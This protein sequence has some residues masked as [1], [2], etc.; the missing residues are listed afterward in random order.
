MAFTESD[1]WDLIHAERTR[2]SQM[3][4]NLSLEHWQTQ[5]LCTKWTIEEVVAHLTAGAHTG[6][7]EWMRSMALAGFNPAIHNVRRLTEHLGRTPQETGENFR[8]ATNLTVAPTTDYPAWLG[9]VIVH[10][11]DIARPL[12][13]KL[14][15]SP[16]AVREVAAYF[17][18]KNFAVNSFTM[19]K[20]LT[21]EANDTDFTVGS[22]PVVRGPL[23]SLVMT[24]AGRREFSADVT[25]SG[26]DEFR[27]RLD[28][29]NN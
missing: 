29:Q 14:T 23:L 28:A 18:A 2:L 13:L 1:Y 8:N 15:P 16:A 5:S 26:A 3:L 19:A 6:R 9:E 21:L 25:G 11:Q 22:G 27:S 12:G 10:S 24:M 17:A 7:W 4:D 20:N